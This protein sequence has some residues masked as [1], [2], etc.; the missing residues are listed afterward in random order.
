MTRCTSL[1]TIALLFFST[2]A[3]AHAL[4]TTPA[5]SSK[6]SSSTITVTEQDNGKDI[7]L[8][9]AG[10]LVVKLKSNP[11]TGYAWTVSGDPSPLRLEK[12]TYVKNSQSAKAVGAPGMQVLRF[13]VSSSGMAT[14]TVIYRR[15]WEYNVA[16]AKTFSV[17]V[18]VR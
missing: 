4:Q 15:S 13:G 9:T 10:T 16:P 8:T 14:L 12:T 7:D 3:L 6:T 18:N 11:S 1:L 2:S 5:T 17:R